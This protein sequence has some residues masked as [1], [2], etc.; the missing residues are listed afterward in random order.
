M[1]R[2]KNSWPLFFLSEVSF[3]LDQSL[4][5]RRRP[6]DIREGLESRILLFQQPYHCFCRSDFRQCITRDLITVVSGSVIAWPAPLCHLANFPPPT[7]D[8]RVRNGE[9]LTRWNVFNELERHGVKGV[10]TLSLFSWM[11]SHDD[12]LTL[13]NYVHFVKLVTDR[14]SFVSYSQS[15]IIIITIVIIISGWPHSPSLTNRTLYPQGTLLMSLQSRRQTSVQKSELLRYLSC[16]PTP[17][18]SFIG[19]GW[20]VLRS[21]IPSL[22][23]RN[24]PCDTRIGTDWAPLFP[25]THTHTPVPPPSPYKGKVLSLFP[26]LRINSRKV[27]GGSGRG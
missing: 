13:D 5:L 1:K 15:M 16:A 18:D 12:T 23:P 4:R 21:E 17:E 7:F 19:S 2:S 24:L 22:S 20:L 25:C 8:G 6:I 10:H 3:S 11:K 27:R 26:R 14:I 9:W